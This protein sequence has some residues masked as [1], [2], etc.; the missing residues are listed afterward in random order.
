KGERQI[1]FGISFRTKELSMPQGNNFQLPDDF[2][3]LTLPERTD[4]SFEPLRPLDSSSPQPSPRKEVS[5]WNEGDRV[6]APWEPSF[7]YVGRIAEIKD[8][9]AVIEFEGGDAGW[10][11]LDQIRTLAVQLRQQVLCRR[12]MGPT[13]FQAEI[14]ETHG[15]EV[16]VRFA[17]GHPDEWIP[18]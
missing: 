1:F 5:P 10:V 13:F 8:S 16:R 18:I 3:D 14:Q 2:P 11:T 12:K 15:D 17:D 6:L 4:Q 7:R 9:Q